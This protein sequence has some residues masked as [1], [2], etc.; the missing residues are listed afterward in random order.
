MPHLPSTRRRA[1]AP[2]F[3]IGP[4]LS[5]AL[6]LAPASASAGPPVDVA[7]HR[8]IYNLELGTTEQRGDVAGAQGAMVLEWAESCEGWEI[9]QRIRL[10]LLTKRDRDIDI[11]S[12]FTS[13]ESKDGLSYRFSSRMQRNGV[14]EEDLRGK[15]SLKGL[16]KAGEAIFSRPEERRVALPKGAMFPTAHILKLI[17]TARRGE[18]LLWRVVFDGAT[19]EGPYELNALIG[20]VIRADA[21]PI[22]TPLGD[23]PFWRI[24]LAYF[25]VGST[26]AMPDW[27]LSVSL[28]EN[29]VARDMVLD[30]G[31]FTVDA[32]LESIDPLPKPDC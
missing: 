1:A 4:A 14:V 16:G 12:S 27:E 26:E 5:A 25:P 31:D 32:V 24:R 2:L 6:L 20:D 3:V 28:Q 8:A 10:R 23:M 17:D 29:G 11:D 7:P 22:T 19:E 21:A 13:S 18:K 30:Y 15:A 9:Q